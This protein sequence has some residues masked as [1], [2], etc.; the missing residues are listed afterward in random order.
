VAAIYKILI[1]L[2]ALFVI[3]FWGIHT[4]LLSPA[5]SPYFGSAQL[6][7]SELQKRASAALTDHPWAMVRMEGQKAIIEGNA[8]SAEDAEAARKAVLQSS[9]TGGLIGGGVT[10]V[11]TSGIRLTDEKDGALSPVAA[12]FTWSATKDATGLVRLTGFVPNDDIR[13]EIVAEA[14]K[15]FPGGVIDELQLARGVPGPEWEDIVK[16]HLAALQLLRDGGIDASDRDF[17]LYGIAESSAQSAEAQSLLDDMATGYASIFTVTAPADEPP[18]TIEGTDQITADSGEIDTESGAD[19]ESTDTAATKEPELT[20]EVIAEIDRCQERFN[21]TLADNTINFASGSDKINAASF[22]LL[23]ELAATARECSDY[24]I[25]IAGHTDSTGS[26]RTNLQ[27]SEA[28]ASAVVSYLTA[29]GIAPDHLTA[30][31]YGDTQP[32]ASNN[33]R[34]GRAQNRRITFTVSAR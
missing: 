27:L 7:E 20:A 19:A 5:I 10:V 3:G 1:G 24:Y 11:D 2:I 33:T 26:A 13:T 17:T 16:Q 31:G 25:E 6:A 22:P 18:S 32:I 34:A 14:E 9:G 15:L 4:N 8:P 12:P 23:D 21:A 30:T 28:R 29:Q